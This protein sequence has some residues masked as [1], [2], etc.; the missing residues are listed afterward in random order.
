MFSGLPHERYSGNSFARLRKNSLPVS[1]VFLVL[2]SLIVLRNIITHRLKNRRNAQWFSFECSQEQIFIHKIKG[3][4]QL[5]LRYHENHNKQKK[6]LDLVSIDVRI[7]RFDSLAL[8][9][10]LILLPIVSSRRRRS[11]GVMC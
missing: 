5:V 11:A 4:D 6:L 9:L 2:A 10:S 3:K 8:S 7:L 1:V